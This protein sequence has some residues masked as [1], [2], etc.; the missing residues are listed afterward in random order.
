MYHELPGEP[1]PKVALGVACEA[2]GDLT[3]AEIWYDTVSRT[4]P[5]FTSAVFGLARCLLSA[6]E[7][8]GAVAAFDRV[9]RSSIASTDAQTAKVEAMLDCDPSELSIDEVL[10]AA[11]VVDGLSLQGEPRA[12]LVAR[13]LQSALAVVPSSP[14]GTTARV[15]GHELSED[16]VR[17]GLESTY[18][19]LAKH[20]GVPR[21]RIDLVDEA[22]RVRPRTLT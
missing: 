8:A 16:G 3:A 11:Q 9:P 6:G 4:D 18:R 12:R 20:A 13:V 1:A 5:S 15:L 10:A 2:A 14:N 19:A 17:R 7:R 22:N 21:E